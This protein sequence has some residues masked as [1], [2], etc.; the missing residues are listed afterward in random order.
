VD[1]E[2]QREWREEVARAG[3]D[4]TPVL[5]RRYFRSIYFREP[6]GV[7]FEIATD[8]PGFAIDEDPERL[9]EELKLPPWL[10]SRRRVLEE[11]LPPLKPPRVDQEAGP[12]ERKLGFEHRFVAGGDVGT[13]PTLLLLHGTG[14]DETDLIPLGDELAPGVN[15]L[16]PRGK[17]LEDGMPRFFRRLA[18]GVFDEEDLKFRTGELADFVEEASGRYG[19]DP[20]NIFA[21]GFSNG[22]NIAGSLLLSNPGLLRGAVLFRPMVPFVPE[23]MPDLSGKPVLIGAGTQDQL[24]PREDTEGLADLL[25]EAGAEVELRWQPSGHGLEYEEVDAA[26]GWLGRVLKGRKGAA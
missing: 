23:T 1:D 7:L 22:A 20:R 12:E 8:S 10:E 25:R 15:L 9:G 13:S 6:G 26:K 14:G 16:S 3:L 18:E 19:F 24:I 21:V 4:V 5:D 11:V 2:Q 17:V